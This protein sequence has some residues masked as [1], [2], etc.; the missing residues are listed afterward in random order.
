MRPIHFAVPLVGSLCLM[1][2]SSLLSPSAAHPHLWA[3]R[4]PEAMWS[5]T[6]GPKQQTLVVQ[7]SV[8][9]RQRRCTT[10]RLPGRWESTLLSSPLGCS[11]AQELRPLA[12]L[13]F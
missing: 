2:S 7:P 13:A 12:G 9:Q 11:L 1:G 3:E 4:S 10:G 8:Q 5:K 6:Q